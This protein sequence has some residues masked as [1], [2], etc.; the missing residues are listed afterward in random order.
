MN[1][2]KGELDSMSLN[3]TVMGAG[4]GG[5]AIASDLKLNGHNVT[6]YEFPEF[7][8]NLLPIMQSGGI[9]ITGVV[10][11]GF[12]VI[13]KIT[14]NIKEAVTNADIIIV[15][16]VANAHERLA[17]LMA[18]HV[19]N[20][21]IIALFPGSGGTLIF[22]KVFKDKA[23]NKK[24]YL[25]EGYTLPYACRKLDGPATIHVHRK[26]FPNLPIGVLPSADTEYVVNKLSSLYEGL[27]PFNHVL[28]V[29]LYNLNFLVHPV[30]TLLN[31]G[32]IEFSN[33]EFWIYKEGFTTSVF[34]LMDVMDEEKCALLEKMGLEPR[35]YHELNEEL[36]Q[37]SFD[38][39]ARISSKGPK[40][41][42]SRYVTEDVPNG[43]VLF[44]SL[45]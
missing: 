44:S 27:I 7:S 12:A 4:N 25:A 1:L 6:L 31:T 2:K 20:E 3:I 24:V 5:F 33:G 17:M 22:D 19:E 30:G 16:A 9:K 43:L 32:R 29:A 11:N 23:I 38:E 26:Q 34:K 37:M 13:D 15:A 39:F 8:D 36:D 21:Q 42:K 18:E 28:E 45:G 40:N 35:T 41:L 10:N 14:T